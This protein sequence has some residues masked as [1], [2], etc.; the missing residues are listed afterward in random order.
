MIGYNFR[1]L[2]EPENRQLV[3]DSAFARDGTRQYKIEGRDAVGGDDEEVIS[4]VITIAYFA[5]DK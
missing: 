1:C 5:S 4:Q 2:P 3:Q